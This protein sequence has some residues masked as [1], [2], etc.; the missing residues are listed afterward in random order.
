MKVPS[1]RFRVRAL[2]ILVASVAL[3]LGGS[4]MAFRSYRAKRYQQDVLF[5]ADWRSRYQ[6]KAERYRSNGDAAGAT[7]HEKLAAYCEEWRRIMEHAASTGELVS[8]SSGPIPP[9]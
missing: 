6:E 9:K 4:R 8:L 5:W 3:V 1:F 2:L 7:K